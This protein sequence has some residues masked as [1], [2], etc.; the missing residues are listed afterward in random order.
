MRDTNRH[1]DGSHCE[2]RAKCRRAHLM[3]PEPE[4]RHCD[5]YIHDLKQPKCLR[6]WLFVQRLPAFDKLLCEENGVNP[7]LF[8]TWDGRR[9]RLT[10]ASRLGD[11]GVTSDFKQQ[12]G[13]ERRVSVE[14]LT[15]FSVTP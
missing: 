4:P 10:M 6:W 8:A 12:M 1:K 11:V 9:V 3:M 5:E 14:E 13:Y 2:D 7:R 15:D